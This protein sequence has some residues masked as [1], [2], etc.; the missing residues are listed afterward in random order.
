MKIDEN[1]MRKGETEIANDVI[2]KICR[3]I[4]EEYLIFNQSQR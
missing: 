3:D 2:F 1:R 4:M